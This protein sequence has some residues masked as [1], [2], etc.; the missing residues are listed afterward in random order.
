MAIMLVKDRTAILAPHLD[1]DFPTHP[2]LWGSEARWVFPIKG[3]VSSFPAPCTRHNGQ[4]PL[5]SCQ[6]HVPNQ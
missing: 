1:E 4:Q 6:V 3:W 5:T 2:R